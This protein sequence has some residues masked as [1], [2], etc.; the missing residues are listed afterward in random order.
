MAATCAPSPGED[1]SLDAHAL[2]QQRLGEV[3]IGH[4]DLAAALVALRTELELRRHIA[5]RDPADAEKREQ[6]ARVVAR[7]GQVLV[8]KSAISACRE[9][10]RTGEAPS[11]L[12]AAAHTLAARG[13]ADAA[14]ALHHEGLAIRRRLAAQSPDNV[15]WSLDVAWSLMAVGEMLAGKG[16][17]A[18]ALAALHEALAIRRALAAADPG[19]DGLR[20]DA[21]HSLTRIAEVLAASGDRAGALATC[22]E[23]RATVQELV[24]R[25][26]S[27]AEWRDDLAAIDAWIAELT[28]AA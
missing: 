28:E 13:D 3:L 6:V 22:R 7:T 11:T 8:L 16:D 21:A 27:R 15:A 10:G 20:C 17:Y 9:G 12:S 1:A 2:R 24:T 23:A 19:N 5:D 25:V 14:L 4:G 18:A 26:P